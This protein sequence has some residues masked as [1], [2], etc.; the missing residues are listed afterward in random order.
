MSVATQSERDGTA[1]PD[2]PRVRLRQQGLRCTP[3][4]LRVLT[5][6]M[7]S[8]RHLSITETWE[9]L[10][11]AGEAIH[12][13]TVYRTLET[14]TAVGVTHAVHGPGPTRYGATGDPHHHT[15]YQRCGAVAALSGEHLVEAAARIEE[16]TGLRPDSS[17]SFLVSG[18][19]A[20]CSG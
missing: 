6:L 18:R 2:E 13:A 5:L 4:R 16:L 1:T 11:R 9:E 19:C 3:G 8:G 7:V 14:L 12:P 20:R 17:G 10:T 15:V